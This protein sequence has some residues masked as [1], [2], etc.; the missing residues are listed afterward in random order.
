MVK[1]GFGNA[2]TIRY[3]CLGSEATKFERNAAFSTLNSEDVSYFKEL[4]GE[5]SVIQ[6]EDVLLAANED[7]MRKYRGS[8]KLLLQPRTTNEVCF[9]FPFCKEFLE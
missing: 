9:F 1:R 6:D 3:R 2:S 5:K 7:W 8:S 4:L